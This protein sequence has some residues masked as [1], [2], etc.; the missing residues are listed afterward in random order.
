MD[1]YNLKEKTIAVVKTDNS[2]KLWKA[3]WASWY[4][5]DPSNALTTVNPLPSI[6]HLMLC[7]QWT[8]YQSLWTYLEGDSHLTRE[9]KGSSMAKSEE[10]SPN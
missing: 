9:D 2:Y 4:S 7:I 3:A 5:R 8:T 1:Y 10:T 6:T